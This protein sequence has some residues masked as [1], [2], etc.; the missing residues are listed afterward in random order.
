MV[1]SV[2]CRWAL[3]DEIRPVLLHYFEKVVWLKILVVDLVSPYK[4]PKLCVLL[5]AP[6]GHGVCFEVVGVL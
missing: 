2:S 3:S 5:V 4:V 1:G 6:T